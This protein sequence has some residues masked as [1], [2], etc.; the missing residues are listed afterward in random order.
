MKQTLN[1]RRQLAITWDIAIQLEQ[2]H[3]TCRRAER[4]FAHHW[5]IQSWSKQIHI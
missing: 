5:Y 3:K 1:T 2:P 4:Q